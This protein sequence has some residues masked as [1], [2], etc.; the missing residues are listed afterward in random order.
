[1]RRLSDD[2]NKIF[3]GM[4]NPFVFTWSDEIPN[5]TWAFPSCCATFYN[6]GL[7]SQTNSHM[8]RFFDEDRFEIYASKDI[9]AGD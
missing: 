2:K 3:D 1:M 4:K 9:K 6:S 7:E 8:I 5:Y